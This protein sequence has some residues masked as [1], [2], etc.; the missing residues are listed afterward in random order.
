MALATDIRVIEA[1]TEHRSFRFRTPLELSTGKITE[2]SQ[3]RAAV[4][5]AD[6]G[7]RSAAGYGTIFLGDLWAW[8]SGRVHSPQRVAAMQALCDLLAT[9]LPTVAEYAHP[10]QVGTALLGDY[11][12]R[13]SAEVTRAR[14]LPEPISHLAAAV[15]LSPLDAAIHDAFGR[16]HGISAYDALD[17]RFLPVMLDKWFG[18]SAANRHI[19]EFFHDPPLP[20]V[21]GWHVISKSDALTRAEERNPIT[22][23]LPNSLEGWIEREGVFAFKIKIT[24]TDVRYDVARTV[25]A[26]RAAREVHER[27][28]TGARIA[29]EV[30]ANEASPS[31]EIVVEYLERLREASA[32][33]YDALRFIEQPTSR[34]LAGNR[35]D[36]RPIA[37]LK[38]VLIDEALQSLEDLPIATELGWS[39]VVLKTCKTHTQTV[40]TIAWCGLNGRPYFIADLTNPGLS[41][42]H[43]AVLAAH[44][45]PLLG[46]ELN[47]RQF[48]PAANDSLQQH[49]PGLARMNQGY[50]DLKETSDVGLGYPAGM[51]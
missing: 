38:P 40:L 4:R 11:L 14:S 47:C 24:G 32:D 45:Q 43:A 31:A 33:A 16:L 9:G 51:T 34:D 25:D 37:R 27:L 28:N 48:V 12:H 23:G 15:C 35:I 41:A 50:F 49:A 19:S 18:T 26:F 13:C 20:K 2:I 36:M 46:V 6:R 22:D 39:G 8:P 10:M 7:G 3:V 21:A 1:N 30:D 17:R 44:S 29:L 5:V 42:V